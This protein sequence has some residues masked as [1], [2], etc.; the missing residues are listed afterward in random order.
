M[1]S[2]RAWR[3]FA[4]SEEPPAG[5]WPTIDGSLAELAGIVDADAAAAVVGGGGCCFAA[6]AA[7]AA[8]G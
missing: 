7:A 5:C 3:L 8:A 4:G 6:V 2:D 1:E